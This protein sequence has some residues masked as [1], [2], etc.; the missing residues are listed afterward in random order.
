MTDWSVEND[1]NYAAFLDR[2]RSSVRATP[3]Q[4]RKIRAIA[5]PLHQAVAKLQALE[6]SGAKKA[7]LEEAI[8][9]FWMY[10]PYRNMR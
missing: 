9:T 1:A 8:K 3:R 4:G 2:W 7:Q 6:Q 10:T 5:A